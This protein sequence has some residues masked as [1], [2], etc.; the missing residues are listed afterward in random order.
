MA[1][2]GAPAGSPGRHHRRAGHARAGAHH[3]HFR[4]LATR[5]PGRVPHRCRRL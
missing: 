5:R 3:G 2:A 1:A 4:R